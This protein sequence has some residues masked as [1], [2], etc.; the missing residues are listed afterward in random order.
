MPHWSEIVLEHEELQFL[1]RSWKAAL[2]QWRGIYYIFD[3]SDARGDVGSASGNENIHG[4][5][6]NY[7]LTGHGGNVLL[8]D[9]DLRNFRFSILQRFSPDMPTEEIVNIESSWKQRLHTQQ[10]GLNR[11]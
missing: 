4:R 6:M 11:N 10:F 8:K 2:S 9:R 3:V 5:W 7:A 1:P